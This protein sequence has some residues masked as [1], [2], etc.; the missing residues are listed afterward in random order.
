MAGYADYVWQVADF[1]FRRSDRGQ[2]DG[3]D[4]PDEQDWRGGYLCGVASWIA[5]Q[6]EPD[7]GA[8][9]R[10]AGC[11]H[12]QRSEEGRIGRGVGHD[13]EVAWPRGP[14]AIALFGG[15]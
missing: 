2:R 11:N 8:C 13:L 6:R 15:G 10:A 5:E 3:I 9:D 12:G 14:L 7:V 4:V 1:G